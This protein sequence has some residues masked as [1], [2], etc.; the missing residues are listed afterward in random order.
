MSTVAEG[1]YVV[2]SHSYGCEREGCTVCGRERLAVVDVR[3][4][5]RRGHHRMAQQI[6]RGVKWP[7]RRLIEGPDICRVCG[8][9][10]PPKYRSLLHCGRRE[11]F[12][13]MD[14]RGWWRFRD[15]VDKPHPLAWLGPKLGL[16]A[17][18]PRLA[19]I[20]VVLAHSGKLVVYV[21]RDGAIGEVGRPVGH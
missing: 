1:E 7:E 10:T 13:A 21:R 4:S 2:Y 19:E 15:A 5:C 11:C 14:A 12:E 17:D 8:E 18:D 6:R 16:A 9:W 20:A 3:H